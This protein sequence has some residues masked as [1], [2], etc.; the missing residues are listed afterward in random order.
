MR[1]LRP[2]QLP[3][4]G[5]MFLG[6]LRSEDRG[7]ERRVSYRI[8]RLRAPTRE[9]LEQQA[10][11]WLRDQEEDGLGNVRWGW[12][13]RRAVKTVTGEWEVELWVQS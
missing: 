4:V 10:R 11:R 7:G 9:E 1:W 2:T 12:D 8:R 5:A 3:G 6:A 13:P